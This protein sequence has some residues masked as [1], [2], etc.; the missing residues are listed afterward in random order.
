MVVISTCMLAFVSL[1]LAIVFAINA[2]SDAEAINIAGSLR[3]Q[4]WRLA[5]Q[6]STPELADRETLAK[7]VTIYGNSLHSLSL[8]R[9]DTRQD[10]I[11]DAY[12]G[13]LTEWYTQM[14]PLLSTRAYHQA[15][16]DQ[17]P[18]FVDSIDHMVKALQQHSEYKLRRLLA[19]ALCALLGMLIMGFVTIRFIK[20]HLLQPINQLGDAADKIRQGVF[21]NLQLSYFPDNEVGQLTHTFQGMADDLAHLY[22]HLEDKVAEQTLALTQS[23]TALH[24]LYDASR[25]LGANPYDG[26]EVSRLITGWQQLLQLQH[27][28][29][30]LSDNAGSHRLQRIDA[31]GIRDTC[32]GECKRCIKQLTDQQ[33]QHFPLTL[34]DQSFGFIYIIMKPNKVLTEESREWLQTFADIVATSLYQHHNRTRE[35]QLLLMEERAVIA[36]ELHDSLAQALSFQKIQLVRL[37]RQLAKQNLT[38]AV[39]DIIA[40]LQEGMNNAYTQLRELLRTFRLPVT[41]GN[42]EKGLQNT[43]EEYRRR[44]PDID[45]SLNYQ[46]RYC[47]LDAPH[48]IHILQIVREAIANAVKHANA[49]NVEICCRQ[50]SQG[51]VVVTVDDN[52]QGLSSDPVKPGHFGTTIMK[53]RAQSMNG[54]IT[55]DKAPLG[56]TRVALE[57]AAA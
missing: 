15:F 50:D 8:R 19:V 57:F 56:G 14:L 40:E 45:F 46:L 27:G 21:S 36:R 25:T 38:P 49:S 16:I 10:E 17:V 44:E 33:T 48:Q 18:A 47:P 7:F 35:R 53:E 13:V 9:L 3:M 6:V 29:I 26:N 54:A 43:L 30:C 11:G 32:T 1:G 20:V 42:L 2:E 34:K 28:Y 39:T 41:E 51:Q 4:S 55:F 24:L 31:N 37:K 22:E 52:G 23:N 5:E 12:R